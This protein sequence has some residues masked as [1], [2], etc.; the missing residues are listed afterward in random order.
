MHMNELETAR[1]I[2]AAIKDGDAEKVR[3]LIGGSDH[4]LNLKTPFGTWLHVA[5]KH[6]QAKI[7]QQLIS[8][9]ADVNARAG[10]FNGAP[11]HLA[12]SEGYVEIVRYLLDHGAELDVSEPERNPLFA[13]IYGGHLDVVKLLSDRGINPHIKYTGK[14]MENMDAL[15]FARERGQSR[16]AEFLATV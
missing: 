13:A 8:L 14:S 15:A 9:G 6:G 3:T 7:V 4:L 12:A 16:I 10:V 2:I 5:A 1:F 11:I